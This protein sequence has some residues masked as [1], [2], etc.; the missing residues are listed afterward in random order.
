MPPR[1]LS[2]E[3]LAE[4]LTVPVRTIYYWRVRGIGPRAIRVGRWLRFDS[5]DVQRWIE[6]RKTTASAGSW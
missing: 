5:R 2:A 4:M 6:D 3:E 1:L